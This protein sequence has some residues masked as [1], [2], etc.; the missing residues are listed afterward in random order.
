MSKIK[1]WVKLSIA[2]IGSILLGVWIGS[3]YDKP[4][5][6]DTQTS[7]PPCPDNTKPMYFDYV[8]G[9][10]HY[11]YRIDRANEPKELPKPSMNEQDVQRYLEKKVPGYLEDTYWGEEYDL[12]NQD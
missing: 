7:K 4:G 2:A 12:D 8:N 6:I 10:W 5:K 11:T 1:L 3:T 9:E